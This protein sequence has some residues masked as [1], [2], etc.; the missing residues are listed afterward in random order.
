MRKQMA[1]GTIVERQ[2]DSALVWEKEAVAGEEHHQPYHPWINAGAV[3]HRGQGDRQER[4][5]G[6]PA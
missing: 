6:L 1:T 5:G 2:V 4:G 3:C